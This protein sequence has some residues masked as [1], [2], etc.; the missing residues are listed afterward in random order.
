MAAAT[1]ATSVSTSRRRAKCSR[2]M[3]IGTGSGH[4]RSAATD[5]K[6]TYRYDPDMPHRVTVVAYEGLSPFELGVAGE[7]FALPRPELAVD[8]WYEF[9]VCAERPGRCG[10]WADS[11]WLS[12]TASR[13]WRG[14]RRHPAG[15]ARRARRS[16]DE[17]VCAPLAAH[18]RGARLVSICSGAFV[19]AATGL[20]DGRRAATHWRYAALLARRYPRVKVVPDVLYVDGDDL[21]TSAGTAAGIDLCLHLVRRDHGADVA[22]RVARRMV[23]AAHRDG[24]Q[25]QFIDLPVP[26]AARGRPD[27]RGDGLGAR[28]ASRARGRGGHG[29]TRPPVTAS[30]QPPL[31]WRDRRRARP[32]GCWRRR[33]DA[34]LPLLESSD[35]P[36]EQVGARV[37]FPTPAAFRRHFARAYGVPPSGGAA[38]SRSGRFLALAMKKLLAVI[39]ALALLAPGLRRGRARRAVRPRLHAAGRR[40][41][42]PD[43]ERRAARAQLGRRAARRGRDAARRPATARSRRS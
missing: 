6:D 37:G 39:P 16:P 36:V 38:P 9:S 41:L 28:P 25:A 4:R 30:V 19:L 5:L 31:P 35:E 20:L 17:L 12:S 18:G 7:V 8:W 23:V 40:A 32:P 10:R 1:S 21:L 43:V 34:A 11:G 2:A 24:G 15:L 29:E 3:L 27:R 33:L 42:L 22:N 26:R 14:P 13:S